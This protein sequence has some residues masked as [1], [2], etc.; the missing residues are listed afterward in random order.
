MLAARD[1]RRD[2]ERA[3]ALF[4]AI[5]AGFLCA[6]ATHVVEHASFH[7]RTAAQCIAEILQFGPY[8]LVWPELNRAS[9]RNDACLGQV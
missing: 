4:E 5:Q 6:R 2:H 3:T 7:L 1:A 9:A 8:R